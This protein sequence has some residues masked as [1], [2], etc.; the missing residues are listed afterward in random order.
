MSLENV[1]NKYAEWRDAVSKYPVIDYYCKPHHTAYAYYKT[2]LD[3]IKGLNY[4][5]KDVEDFCK[6]IAGDSKNIAAL[7]L[8]ALVNSIIQDNETIALKP[9]LLLDCFGYRHQKGRLIIE[10][11][12]GNLACFEMIGGEVIVDNAGYFTGS[13]MIGGKLIVKGRIGSLACDVKAK[14]IRKGAEKVIL[15][16]SLKEKC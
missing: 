2:A 14:K 8:S 1:I 4:S 13:R 6:L 3:A 10:G 11:N 12:A 7:Y 9:N 5:K 15:I 16:E